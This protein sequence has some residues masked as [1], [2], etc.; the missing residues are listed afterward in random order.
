M[1]PSAQKVADAARELGLDVEIVPSTRGRRFA[2]T[3]DSSRAVARGLFVS[4]S[5]AIACEDRSVL[6]LKSHQL[7]LPPKRAA[8]R[9]MRMRATHGAFRPL[10]GIEARGPVGERC[11]SAASLRA[12]RRAS[13]MRL[14]GENSR[15]PEQL[16]GSATNQVH[17]SLRH[18]RRA[19]LCHREH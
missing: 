9:A 6:P 11:A 1:H 12:F 5:G 16:S 4:T 18:N 17:P 19:G 13:L 7:T 3:G 10:C 15:V 2:R 14:I 8:R